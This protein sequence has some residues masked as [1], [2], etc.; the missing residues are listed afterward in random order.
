MNG[1]VGG[2]LLQAV[3]QVLKADDALVLHGSEQGAAIG[4]LLELV[5]CRHV[6]EQERQVIDLQQ[7]RVFLELGKGR[8]QQ[9]H[10]AKKERFE[11]LSVAEKLGVGI[12]LDHD[13]VAEAL[14]HEIAEF[15]G[16]DPLGGVLGHHVGKFDDDGSSDGGRSTKK[17]RTHR[18]RKNGLQFQHSRYPPTVRF[19]WICL[20]P[21]TACCKIL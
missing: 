12:D 3:V 14:R 19:I 15:V 20:L 11:F 18:K 2:D 10:V 13:L 17:N 5:D 21:D 16:H 1:I 8:G 6:L 4:A 7:G 9:V